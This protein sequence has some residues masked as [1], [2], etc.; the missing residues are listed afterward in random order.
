VL[1]LSDPD[2]K[3]PTYSQKRFEAFRAH[4]L[5]LLERANSDA[6]YALLAFLTKHDQGAL[7]Q[8]PVIE[9]RRA[10]LLKGG[11]L[12]FL[13]GGEYAH[14]DPAIRR[15]WEDYVQGQD[16]EQ[17]QC[18]V[19]GEIA[20][21]ERLHARLKGV[22]GGQP[23]GTTLVGFNANAYESYNRIQGQNSPISQRAAFAYTTVLNYLLSDANPNRKLLLG[24]ATVVYWAESANRK[25][26]SAFLNMRYGLSNHRSWRASSWLACASPCAK[27]PDQRPVETAR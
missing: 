2:K 21:V 7:E 5:A 4:N 17:M 11:N 3:D 20:P 22:R 6:A 27:L 15:V 26:E 1:G 19:T 18:L 10:D 24:D 16:A 23:I 12:V 25:Y 8:H 9:A 14:H 13:F